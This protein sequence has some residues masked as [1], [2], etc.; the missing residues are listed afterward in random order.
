MYVALRNYCSP[1]HLRTY[2]YHSTTCNCI[3]LLQVD[4][5]RKDTDDDQARSDVPTVTVPSSDD[6]TGDSA[7]QNSNDPAVCS[8]IPITILHK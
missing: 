6:H 3:A 1:I 2:V 5:P 4:D 8:Y 7:K